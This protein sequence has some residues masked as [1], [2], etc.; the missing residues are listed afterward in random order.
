MESRKITVVGQGQITIMSCAETLG[1]LKDDFKEAKIAYSND[2][3]FYE[4]VSRTNLVDDQSALPANILYKGQRT[5]DLV[6]MMTLKNKKIMSGVITRAELYAGVKEGGYQDEVKTKF[7]KNFTQVSSADLEKFLES[8]NTKTVVTKVAA[9]TKSVKSPAASVVP[10]APATHVD[11]TASVKPEVPVHNCSA[12]VCKKA[13]VE[14]VGVLVTNK[15]ISKI[16]ETNILGILASDGTAVPT[17][18]APKAPAID[19]PFSASELAD[20]QKILNK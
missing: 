5:S 19:S 6:I 14:L 9:S 20:M 2:T 4:G 18:V 3:A 15:T 16:Q 7:D 11:K 13:I 1:A 17:Y 8:K 10:T 12:D